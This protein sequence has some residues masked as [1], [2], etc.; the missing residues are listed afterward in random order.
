MICALPY[1]SERNL[2][3]SLVYLENGRKYHVVFLVCAMHALVI[4]LVVHCCE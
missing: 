4:V 1:H 3:P 2:R